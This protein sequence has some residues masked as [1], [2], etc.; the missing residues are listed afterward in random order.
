MNSIIPILSITGS[1]NTSGAGI[2]ADIKTITDLGGYAVTAIS[3]VT[4]QNQSGVHTLL[5][6]PSDIVI[7][8]VHSVIDNFHPKA[9]KLGIMGDAPTIRQLRTEI[10]GCPKIVCDPG[11]LSSHGNRLMTDEAIHSF[12]QYILPITQLLIIRC[13]EAELILGE[14]IQTD[15]DMVRAAQKLNNM[16]VE[17]IFLRGGMHT[18]GRVTALLYGKRHKHFVS[19]YNIEGWQRH[20][21][22]GALSSAIATRLGLGDDVPTA[23]TK[24]HE[25][26]HSQVVYAIKSKD[27]NLRAADLYNQLLSLITDHYHEAHDVT[28][29]AEKLAITPRYLSQITNKLVG[30]SPKDVIADYL[31]QK[32]KILLDTSRLNIQEIAEKLG[33]SSQVI[34]CK[35]FRAHEGVSASAY[36]QSHPSNL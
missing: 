20:G 14:K 27:H 2:Q 6:L 16:G 21:V 33:F 35:F 15:D 11:I 12:T 3:S 36:R 4:V 5:H 26:M 22:G 29:Y 1:D 31:I 23:I 25:Y 34:F 10:V 30:K 13:N 24:A 28:F 32:A 8:Q 9:I 18:E 7:G 17:W 19:S